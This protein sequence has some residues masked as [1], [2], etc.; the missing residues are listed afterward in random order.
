MG[1]SAVMVVSDD[2]DPFHLSAGSPSTG[3]PASIFRKGADTPNPDDNLVYTER[4]PANHIDPGSPVMGA[5]RRT[6]R[7]KR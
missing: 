6:R 4:R 5:R 3:Q 7:R 2:A 1:F